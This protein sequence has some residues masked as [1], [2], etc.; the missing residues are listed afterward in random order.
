MLTWV[1]RQ[2]WKALIKVH[3]I[4]AFLSLPYTYLLFTEITNESTVAICSVS[5]PSYS[6]EEISHW[7]LLS[8]LS[9]PS[10]AGEIHVWHSLVGISLN[11][12]IHI[13]L[14]PDTRM[15]ISVELILRKKSQP[16]HAEIGLVLPAKTWCCYLLTWHPHEDCWSETSPRTS[17][18]QF[19]TLMKGE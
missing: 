7:S 13:L 6:L 12:K 19:E 16:W 17:D 9:S 1:Q 18:S 15:N 5:A 4:K 14:D 8:L 10:L 11:F 3:I 2:K